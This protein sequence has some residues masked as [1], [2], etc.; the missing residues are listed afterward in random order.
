MGRVTVSQ[1][2]KVR[3]YD[4]Y[5][6]KLPLML[7]WD[8]YQGLQRDAQAVVDYVWNDAELSKVPIVSSPSSKCLDVTVFICPVDYLW[9]VFRGSGS[10]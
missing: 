7:E 3:V 2:R 6:L 4:Y 9:A 5:V 8:T 10:D 1:A